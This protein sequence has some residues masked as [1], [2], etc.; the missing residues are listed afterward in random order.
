M[1]ML[2]PLKYCKAEDIFRFDGMELPDGT[3]AITV[4]LNDGKDQITY[5]VE[6][7]LV[8]E[9]VN[10]QTRIN[11]AIVKLPHVILPPPTPVL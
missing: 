10:L 1:I 4:S 8:Q 2:T 6:G 3:H 9:L 5:R 11:S 7:N